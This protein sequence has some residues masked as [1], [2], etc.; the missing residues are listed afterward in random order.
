MTPGGKLETLKEGEPTPRANLH[1]AGTVPVTMKP[2][3]LKEF[4]N[5]T[6]KDALDKKANELLNKL[7][8]D[9]GKEQN[10]DNTYVYIIIFYL[11]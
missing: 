2:A 10:N 5:K 8:P 1:S 4:Q 11:K 7:E 3:L 9:A 6:P